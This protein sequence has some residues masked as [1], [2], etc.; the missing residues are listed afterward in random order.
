VILR[1]RAEY[2]PSISVMVDL[3]ERSRHGTS[4]RSL[5]LPSGTSYVPLTPTGVERS[6]S[7]VYRVRN[8]GV[9]SGQGVRIHGA[10][11]RTG[12]AF[13]E[14]TAPESGESDASE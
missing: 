12:R 14:P 2:D 3:V 10:E 8:R 13:G 5:R 9:A 1:L 7:L 11:W 6:V 4:R